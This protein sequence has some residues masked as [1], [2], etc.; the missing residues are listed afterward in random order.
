MDLLDGSFLIF[1]PSTKPLTESNKNPPRAGYR[2]LGVRIYG[3]PEF[4]QGTVYPI[5]EGVV[6]YLLWTLETP[7]GDCG[8][9]NMF[10]A[11][12]EEGLPC[13]AWKEWNCS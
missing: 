10:I 3:Q 5:H 9:E 6:A 1:K 12:N 11:L 4:A 8:Q 13:R 7:Y 2:L